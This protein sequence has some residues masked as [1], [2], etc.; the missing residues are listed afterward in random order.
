[1]Q[2][3]NNAL[4]ANYTNKYS[5]VYNS[6]TPLTNTSRN[7]I[8]ALSCRGRQLTEYCNSLSKAINM[9]CVQ[10]TENNDS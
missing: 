2:Q 3:I 7:R 4:S 9:G 10:S 6:V 5:T 8:I 1:M